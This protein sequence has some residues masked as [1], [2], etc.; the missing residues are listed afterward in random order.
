MTQSIKPYLSKATLSL[1]ERVA[2]LPPP[3]PGQ[4]VSI[5][6]ELAPYWL[7][8][9]HQQLTSFDER[10]FLYKGQRH[11]LHSSEAQ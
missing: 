9:H 6:L 2:Q 10:R 7:K 3:Q 1:D 8:Y 4:V 11:T 5:P